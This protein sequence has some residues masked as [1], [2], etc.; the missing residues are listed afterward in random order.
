MPHNLCPLI[1]SFNA[2]G[3]AVLYYAKPYPIHYFLQENNF[4]F[5]PTFSRLERKTRAWCTWWGCT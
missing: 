1:L 2:P 5:M 4:L 3:L